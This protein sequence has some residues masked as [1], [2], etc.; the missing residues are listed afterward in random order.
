MVGAEQVI[1]TEATHLNETMDVPEWQSGAFADEEWAVFEGRY[2]IEDGQ[3]GAKVLTVAACT[4]LPHGTAKTR[5][6]PSMS[7][8]N[9]TNIPLKIIRTSCSAR[10]MRRGALRS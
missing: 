7:M 9:P 5:A 1:G 2:W 6:T 10:V 8:R 3:E 4:G